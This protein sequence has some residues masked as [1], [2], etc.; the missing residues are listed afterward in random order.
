[1]LMLTEDGKIK[2]LDFDVAMEQSSFAQSNA[3]IVGKQAY[4][5]LEQFRG[6]PCVQSD[7]YA[8]GATLTFLLTG[9]EPAA[10]QSSHP[11]EVNPNVSEELDQLISKATALELADRIASAAELR[12]LLQGTPAPEEAAE[13]T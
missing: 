7:I 4:I 8:L 6:K 10:L 12:A 3:T 13:V 5:P 2:L 9:Q 1:N 11:R